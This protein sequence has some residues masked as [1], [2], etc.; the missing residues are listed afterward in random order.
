[1]VDVTC[2]SMKKI[3]IINLKDLRLLL[4]ERN[5]LLFKCR[6]RGKFELFGLG[7]TEAPNLDNRKDIDVE[8]FLLELIA[9]I[10]VINIIS[11]W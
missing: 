8:W 6:H 7:T 3:S 4:N 11:R 5:E 2:L 9:F 1:M 10:T